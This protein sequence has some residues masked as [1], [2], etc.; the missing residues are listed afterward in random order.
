VTVKQVL[1][2]LERNARAVEREAERA[3]R[4]AER[5]AVS[6]Y[7]TAM[8]AQQQANAAATVSSY[9]NY[10]RALVGY[11]RHG[12]AFIDWFALLNSTPPAP[13][14][15]EPHM[16][17]AALAALHAY[18][19]TFLER[20]LGRDR[21]RKAELEQGVINARLSD[22]R[23]FVDA[24][25]QYATFYQDWVSQRDTA[26]R[27]I[28][29][30]VTLYPEIVES[31]G[32]LNTFEGLG[33][34]IAVSVV[35]PDLIALTVMGKFCQVVPAEEVKLTSTGKLTSK[36][37]A[38]GKYWALVQD[39]ICSCAIRIACDTFN[40]LPIN[41]VIVNLGEGAINTV[42]GYPE[43]A[44]IV[45][46]HFTRS[47][48]LRINLHGIDP[49]DSMANFNVRMSFHKNKGFTPVEPISPD[50]HWVTS[51]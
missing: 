45:A 42:T 10:L 39:H 16:E 12:V 2:A 5:V 22:Q 1:R 33:S 47:A 50:E 18:Q 6:Q 11:H 44:T 40:V 14:V 29:R 9:D 43:I 49:S 3:R 4:E 31:C 21:T 48:M 46:V 26:H 37:M 27:I 36:A 25:Q 8:L 30:D 32:I 24:Q 28:G 34:R 17:R 20:T 7:K 15:P 23:M 35:E 19:P 13:P 51:G 41:R 38:A